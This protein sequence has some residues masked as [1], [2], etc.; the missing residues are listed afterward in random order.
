[1]IVDGTKISVGFFNYF[2]HAATSPES[3]L[4]LE[5]QHE[6]FDATK[7][8]SEQ[9]Y[10]E[11]TGM[12]WHDFFVEAAKE[13]ISRIVALSNKGESAG[14]TLFDEQEEEIRAQISALSKKAA[15]YNVLTNDYA[16]IIYGDFV[17][18]ATL[19]K[20]MQKSYIAQ[21]YY[22]FISIT[23]KPSANETES[24]FY[25]N[26]EDFYSVSFDYYI[27]NY[28]DNFED[29]VS[30]INE[31]LNQSNSPKEFDYALKEKFPVY[32]MMGFLETESIEARD[33]M[34]KDSDFL[35]QEVTDWVYGSERKAG[36]KTFIHVKD[37]KKLYVILMSEPA[38][39]DT[40]VKCSVREIF[41]SSDDSSDGSVNAMYLS[42]EIENKIRTSENPEYTFAVLADMYLKN[43]EEMQ[44]SGGLVGKISNGDSEEKLNS[45][46]FDDS[47][48]NGD[49]IS[50]SGEK[51]FYIFL[52]SDRYES[53]RFDSEQELISVKVEKASIAQETK[54]AFA[55][56]KHVLNE[57][58]RSDIDSA[59]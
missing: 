46:I 25:E 27:V 49:I 18:K 42:E 19:E 14:I 32:D 56:E 39:L 36:E 1:M 20:I 30:L 55:Y 3:L 24:Y 11:E 5:R 9:I 7:S 23:Q 33:L 52:F 16:S 45:W 22:E 57:K 44:H 17:G 51:G 21:N 48:K 13:Q 54:N 47:R 35:P 10:D 41:I 28:D 43:F 31:V 53:W 59:E 38:Q 2:Y 15:E 50:I 37:E 40:E 4:M 34:K 6:G 26:Q 8:F 29:Q 58:T 12:T